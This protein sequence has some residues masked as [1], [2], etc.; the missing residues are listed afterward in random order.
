MATEPDI[1]G[2]AFQRTAYP[3]LPLRAGGRIGLTAWVLV[4]LVGIAGV[5]AALTGVAAG[6]LPRR[7]TAAQ[8]Q[9][10]TAWEFGKR[11]RT[12]PA[13]KIFPGSVRYQ[14]PASALA[15]VD[16]LTL[17]ARRVGISPQAGC[18]TTTDPAAASV[19]ARHGCQAIL[20]ATYADATGSYVVTIGIAVLPAPGQAAAAAGQLAGGH[21][22]RGFRPGV[23]ALLFPHTV[24]ARFRDG[25]RQLTS[26]FAAG[27]YVVFYAVGYA[28][29]R[30]RAQVADN[31]YA[32]SEMTSVA[33]G[34]ARSIAAS[35]GA[36]PAAPRCP[37]APGC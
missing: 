32:D 15:D 31:P 33:G 22:A 23:R 26:S 35:F 3:R 4:L 25:Q 17:T 18:A 24:A 29:G 12:W 2:G 9:Q 20:R 6:V 21:G 14:L 27:S 34:V 19:L 28:D 37:G 30:P 16:G 5:A 11:W 1:Q 8:Q 13:G 10:I 36:P 7:F